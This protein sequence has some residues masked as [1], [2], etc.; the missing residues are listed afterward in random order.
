MKL[1]RGDVY[2]LYPRSE[3]QKDTVKVNQKV[4]KEYLRT[5]YL[6]LMLIYWHWFGY[7]IEEGENVNYSSMISGFA[8]WKLLEQRRYSQTNGQL[9]GNPNSKIIYRKNTLK[10]SL[11]QKRSRVHN[12]NDQF[13]FCFMRVF[14]TYLMLAAELTAR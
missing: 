3:E 10:N 13:I 1:K 12:S 7:K 9:S 14:M 8:K 11:Y 6:T 4:S 5:E 2:S